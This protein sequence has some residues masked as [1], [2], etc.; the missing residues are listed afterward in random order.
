MRRWEREG[1]VGIDLPESG[2]LSTS[3]GHTFVRDFN[4]VATLCV[5]EELNPHRPRR[6]ANGVAQWYGTPKVMAQSGRWV[7]EHVDATEASV[8]AAHRKRQTTQERGGNDSGRQG[9]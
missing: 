7:V 6:G 8:E 4:D 9:H 3:G 2:Y 5:L 1:Y